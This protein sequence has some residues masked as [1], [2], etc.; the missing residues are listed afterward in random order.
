MQNIIRINPKLHIAK[1]EEVY[2]EPIIVRVTKFDEEGLAH[3]EH[4]IENAL[5]SEQPVIPV[6]IDSFGGSSYAV[7]GMINLL[8]TI[9]IPVATILTAKAMSAGAILFSFGTEGYRFMHPESWMM[10]HDV[11][12]FTGGKIEEIK[13]DTNQMD[14][15]NQRMYKRMS[16]H[17][18]H[19]PEYIG[20]LIKGHNHVDWFLTAKEAKKHN[21]ANHLKVPK[22]EIEIGLQVRFG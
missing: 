2:Q 20:N 21:I 19:K 1:L 7:L 4:D 3:F 16:Q 13:A 11:G 10:I 22:F 12:S 15:M 8:D 18:G 17:L 6:V 9:T 5:N 14:E